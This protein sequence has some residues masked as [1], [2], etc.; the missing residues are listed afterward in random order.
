L[1]PVGSVR[2]ST[3]SIWSVSCSSTAATSLTPRRGPR[4]AR[5]TSSGVST[6]VT[7]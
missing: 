7:L 6:P 1:L 4:P 2:R 3:M 5:P